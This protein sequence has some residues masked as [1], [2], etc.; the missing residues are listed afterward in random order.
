MLLRRVV[1]A[2]TQSLVDALMAAAEAAGGC[3]HRNEGW[4]VRNS[5]TCVDCGRRRA[6]TLL[7][8]AFHDRWARKTRQAC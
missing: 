7:D 8:P 4:P 1:R 3:Q 5:R 2:L 6:Y